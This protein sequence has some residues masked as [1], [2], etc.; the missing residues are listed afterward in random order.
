ME[1]CKGFDV[2]DDG[3]DSA[4]FTASAR[5]HPRAGLKGHTMDIALPCEPA[6]VVYG[7]AA[8]RSLDIKRWSM[9][10]D[11]GCV[12]GRRLTSLVLQRPN[13]SDP[14]SLRARAHADDI[15][16]GEED[17]KL[18][19]LAAIHE[20][21]DLPHQQWKQKAQKVRFGEDDAGIEA[22]IISV[23]CPDMGD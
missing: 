12:Y 1:L 23:R 10:V 15:E 19:G 6:T 20:E 11:T 7:H 18:D 8:T 4:N 22:H 16:S 14:E 13:P 2:D 17:E 3:D 9:G 21:P 5:S